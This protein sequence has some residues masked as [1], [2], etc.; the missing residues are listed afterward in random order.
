MPLVKPIRDTIWPE[1]SDEQSAAIAVKRMSIWIFGRAFLLI[2][3]GLLDLLVCLIFAPK[4]P[5]GTSAAIGFVWY[6]FGAGLLFALIAW[7]VSRKSFSWAIAGLAI[8]AV[9]AIAIL[10]SPIAF[11]ICL[12]LVLLFI[13]A[14][15]ATSKFRGD[16]SKD[17][18]LPV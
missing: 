9:G 3:I 17:A 14:V 15:R 16:R 7:R 1:V 6:T 11:I 5:E 4:N 8:C 2:A 10:P 12:F 13:N 18:A